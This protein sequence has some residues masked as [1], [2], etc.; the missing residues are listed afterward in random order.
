MNDIILRLIRHLE[1]F[2]S[3]EDVSVQWAKDTETILDELGDIDDALDE[4]Q[5]YLSLYRPEGG[6]HL[7]NRNQM[8]EFCRRIIPTLKK[9]LAP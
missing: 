5:E 6:P 8:G 3:G 7:Y 4:L 1:R 2:V 9:R